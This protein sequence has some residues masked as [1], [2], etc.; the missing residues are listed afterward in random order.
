MNMDKKSFLAI[1]LCVLFYLAYTE[2]LKRRY[3]DY[4]KQPSENKKAEEVEKPKPKEQQPAKQSGVET[5]T[6]DLQPPRGPTEE[7]YKKLP[8]LDL[9]VETD[10]VI[11]MFDQEYSAITS[12]KLKN[13]TPGINT[14]PGE[15][16]ELLQGPM[17]IQGVILRDMNNFSL[18]RGFSASREGQGLIFQRKDGVFLI[19]QK[20]EPSKNGYDVE[21]INTFENTSQN[22]EELTVGLLTQGA[23]HKTGESG[24]FLGSSNYAKSSTLIY[25]VGGGRTSEDLIK[26]CEDANRDLKSFQLKDEKIDFIGYDLHYFLMVF[27]P[28]EKISS[29]VRKSDGATAN[30]CPISQV[31]Y[32]QY[33]MVK[34][35]EK[36]E[37]KFKGYFGPKDVNIL[38]EHGK[39]LEK[40]VD[41]GWFAVIAYPLLVAINSIYRLVQNYGVAIIILTTIL[42]ILFYPLTKAA[43]VSMK[44]MQKL[45]P[46]MNKIREKYKD[47]P[48]R[49]QKEI[50]AF[51]SKHKVNP[52]KGCL[53]ILPQIPVFIAFYNV[54]SQSIELR[55][56][57]FYL[58]IKD[59]SSA[60]P[61]YVTPLILGVFMFVQQKLTPNPGMDKNQARIMMMM[62]VIF[63]VMMLSMPAG[64]VLYMMTNTII[65][66]G[67]QQW[68]NKKLDKIEIKA[69]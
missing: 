53:P 59:L 51:M 28:Q 33:G 43:A 36:V 21:I 30:Y 40:T 60:D 52:A 37:L 14:S 31:F 13:Y 61:Y 67:Q 25:G 12:I 15:N 56:A 57:P 54:L 1:L 8:P 45:Q 63:T 48:Q 68:L 39:S 24:G 22:Q 2:Y 65:S 47:D 55:H 62:P 26:F 9:R 69:V 34:P 29:T 44:R 16:L 18:N 49:Q 4:G 58:W 11:Y 32:Q 35:G 10:N 6:A 38:R 46:D 41:F 7:G 23:F 64:M 20:I 3:P 27:Q 50:M 42:K 66:I 5:K 19:T 17:A